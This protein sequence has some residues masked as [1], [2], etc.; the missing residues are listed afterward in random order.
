MLTPA[1]VL[2]YITGHDAQTDMGLYTDVKTLLT[3]IC[4]SEAIYTMF[5]ATSK[6]CMHVRRAAARLDAVVTR[7]QAIR[8]GACQRRAYLQ[9]QQRIVLLQAAFRAFPARMQFLQAKGAAIWI[10]SCWRRHQAQQLILNIKVRTCALPGMLARTPDCCGQ[11]DNAACLMMASAKE[12]ACCIQL[13][14]LNTP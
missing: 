14:C 9:T 8:R 13:L 5:D 2:T 11:S 7:L 10:Q 6:Q 12:E 3:C 1:S 4:K